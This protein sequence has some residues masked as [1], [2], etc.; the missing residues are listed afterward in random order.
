MKIDALGEEF[1]NMTMGGPGS[2]IPDSM[3]ATVD[4]GIVIAGNGKRTGGYDLDIW[5]A[6]LK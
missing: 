4:G 2:Q 3:S 1:W 5:L 6:K